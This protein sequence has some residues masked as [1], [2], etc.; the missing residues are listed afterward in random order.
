MSKKQ[1]QK[2]NIKNDP[3]TIPAPI[4]MPIT[5]EDIEIMQLIN[6]FMRMTGTDFD[7]VAYMLGLSAKGAKKLKDSYGIKS[8]E[9]INDLVSVMKKMQ[10][11]G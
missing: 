1:Q 4:Q 3:F 6:A 2:L 7:D 10:R 8:A 9:H 5:Q 11:A